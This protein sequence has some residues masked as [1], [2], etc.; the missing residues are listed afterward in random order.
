MKKFLFAIVAGFIT[1]LAATNGASAQN[2][3]NTEI[4]ESQK[5]TTAVE[6]AVTPANDR[7]VDLSAISPKA[8]KAFTKAYKNVTGESW[9]KNSDGFCAK[10]I[11]NGV[12]NMVFYHNNGT[13]SGSLKG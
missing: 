9:E 12:K 6:K 10:F 5:N 13:W 4:L 11:S 3:V 1:A 7:I 2:S 8:L